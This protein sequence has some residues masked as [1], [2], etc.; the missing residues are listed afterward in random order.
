MSVASNYRG[1]SILCTMAKVFESLVHTAILPSVTNYITHHRHGYMPKRSTTTWLSSFIANR[2]Y[3]VKIENF[4]S[5]SFIGLSGVP[6]GSALSPLLFILY[7]NDC[8]NIL[9]SDGH[10]LFADDLKI[11]LPVSS[12]VDCQS[13]QSFF[14]K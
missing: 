7:I 2:S 10:L 9:P 3:T 5:S 1:V 6:Q 8:I 13:L 14:F 4:L 12:I 11:F